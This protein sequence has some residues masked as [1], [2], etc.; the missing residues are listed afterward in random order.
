[1]EHSMVNKILTFDD[2]IFTSHPGF[3][4][5]V[6]AKVKFNNGY[7]MSIQGGGDSPGLYGDGVN[8]FE[9]WASCDDESKRY[10]TSDQ[11]TQYM[12]SIQLIK[13]YID[14]FAF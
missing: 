1:M 6:L 12:K 7:T 5:G 2:L 10:L 13:D 4:G 14:P 3:R 9:A 11:I 8:T